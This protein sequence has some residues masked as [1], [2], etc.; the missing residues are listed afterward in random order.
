MVVKRPEAYSALDFEARKVLMAHRAK[1][2]M[3][4]PDYWFSGF[5]LV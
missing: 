4:N 1:V 3:A 2:Y 5:Q